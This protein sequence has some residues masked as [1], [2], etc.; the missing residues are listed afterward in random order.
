V[1]INVGWA[2]PTIIPEPV[3]IDA[4]RLLAYLDHNILGAKGISDL[5]FIPQWENSFLV[6]GSQHIDILE[7][8]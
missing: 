2:R 6:T 1:L 7:T 8:C 3:M 5:D 4:L